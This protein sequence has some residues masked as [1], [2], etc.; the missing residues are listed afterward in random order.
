MGVFGVLVKL[1]P[2]ITRAG[3]ILGGILVADLV[4]AQDKSTIYNTWGDLATAVGSKQNMQPSTNPRPGDSSSLPAI[5]TTLSFA[6]SDGTGTMFTMAGYTGKALVV[7]GFRLIV[8]G[9]SG[10]PQTLL[11]NEVSDLPHTQTDGYLFHVTGSGALELDGNFDVQGAGTS[12]STAGVILAEKGAY[13]LMRGIVFDD[14]IGKTANV[15]YMSDPSTRADVNSCRFSKNSPIK[16]G[17]AIYVNNG[18][19]LVITDPSFSSPG[20]SG[21]G[22]Y[23]SSGNVTFPACD[24]DDMGCNWTPN[25]KESGTTAEVGDCK[26]ITACCDSLNMD[27][28]DSNDDVV[29]R[30]FRKNIAL[31]VCLSIMLVAAI[32]TAVYYRKKLRKARHHSDIRLTDMDL[33]EPLLQD[34]EDRKNSIADE[35]RERGGSVVEMVRSL[36]KVD[37]ETNNSAQAENWQIEYKQLKFNQRIGTGAYGAVFDGVYGD[38]KLPVAIKRITL[39]ADPDKNKGEIKQA[40]TEVSMHSYTSLCDIASLTSRGLLRVPW[41]FRSTNPSLSSPHLPSSPLLPSRHHTY[42]LVTTPTLSSPLTPLLPSRP[43]DADPVG[44]APP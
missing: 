27:N 35:Y 18:A 26:S 21:H 34:G 13:V 42:P 30:F 44:V 33:G 24:D 9:A 1:M 43:S 5:D 32:S 3:V 41:L 37:T 10:N 36:W 29:E 15:L 16:D 28:D 31:V 19:A 22:I 4:S 17:G 2:F 20:G 6:T 7:D 14:C 12:T 39:S 25:A 11:P 38:T 8:R 40:Q 23:T